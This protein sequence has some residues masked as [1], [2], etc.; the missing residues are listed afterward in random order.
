V[1]GSVTGK[2]MSCRDGCIVL[3]C[4]IVERSGCETLDDL[5]PSRDVSIGEKTAQNERAADSS[6]KVRSTAGC[7]HDGAAAYS[8]IER[9][10][11]RNRADRLVAR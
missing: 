1:P 4:S 5:T 6:A 9:M 8:P 7:T 2:L 3:A 10:G 11:D